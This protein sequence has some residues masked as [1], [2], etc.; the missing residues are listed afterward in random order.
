MVGAD[1]GGRWGGVEP[2]DRLGQ[3]Q[4]L[5]ALDEVQHVAALAAA[6][7]VPALGVAVHREA[8]LALLVEG[9][10]AL[11]DTPPATKRDA[12]SFHHLGEEVAALE[13]GEVDRGGAGRGRHAGTPGRGRSPRRLRREVVL[14]G[15]QR[16]PRTAS[17]SRELPSPR[18][19]STAA[20]PVPGL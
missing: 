16:I 18:G 17:T 11:A 2:P 20:R 15:R 7:A 1:H 9:A 12:R 14:P 5:G 13:G 4:A 3:A 6:E 8:A 19:A 10:D